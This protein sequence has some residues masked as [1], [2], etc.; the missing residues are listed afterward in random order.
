MTNRADM[1]DNIIDASVILAI[2]T[3]I[4]LKLCGV[5]T[6]PWLWLTCPLWIPFIIGVFLMLS[7]ITILTTKGILN[8]I[9]EKKNER[10]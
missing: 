3:V 7:L 6:L 4:I 8:L 5:I 2:L 9:K 10:N 1:V